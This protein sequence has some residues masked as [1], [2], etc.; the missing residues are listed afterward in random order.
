MFGDKFIDG[1]GGEEEK[2]DIFFE[3]DIF[4]PLI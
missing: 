2:R 1:K 4:A 3:I